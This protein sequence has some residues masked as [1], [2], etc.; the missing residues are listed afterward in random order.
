MGEEKSIVARRVSFWQTLKAVA[1]SF[2][3][4]RKRSG[5]ETDA[6]Q[7]N[8]IYVIIIG[9]LLAAIFVGVLVTIVNI[10]VA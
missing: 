10:V 7:L 5:Y 4:I 3:G 8:P 2:L 9:V 6:A 1:W